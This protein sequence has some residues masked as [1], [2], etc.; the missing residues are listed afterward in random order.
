[1]CPRRNYIL[2]YWFTYA[3]TGLNLI[4]SLLRSIRTTQALSK[5]TIDDKR[6]VPFH[7]SRVINSSTISYILNY[8]R[9][10]Y[11]ICPHFYFFSS[12]TCSNINACEKPQE[13]Q[14]TIIVDKDH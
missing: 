1:M 12:Y 9:D 7:C 3:R 14:P 11:H 13:H 8:Y 6:R 4:H 10:I 2:D 5:I